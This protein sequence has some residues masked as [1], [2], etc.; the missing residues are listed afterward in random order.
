M[1]KVFQIQVLLSTSIRKGIPYQLNTN[2]GKSKKNSGFTELILISLIQGALL[3][4][5][6]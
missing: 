2:A 4:K 3:D 1:G 6:L 5:F